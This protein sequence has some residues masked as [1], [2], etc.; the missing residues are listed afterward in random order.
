M[1]SLLG[2]TMV[3]GLVLTAAV[4]L[5]RFNVEPSCRSA[6]QRAGDTGYLSVCLRKE[7]EARQQIERQWGEF[8]AAD[9]SK[10]IPRTRV[11]ERGTYTELLTCLEL[12]RDVRRL[13]AGKEPRTTGQ[14]G[15]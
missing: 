4:P 14:I 9:R 2:A 1:I 15:K 13:P 5:P 12:S 11:F 8:T 3:G 6:A 7:Q 10:C